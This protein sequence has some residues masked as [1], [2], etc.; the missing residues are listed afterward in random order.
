MKLSELIKELIVINSA[1][2]DIEVTIS[3]MNATEFSSLLYTFYDEDSEECRLYPE[4][5]E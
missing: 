3:N 1:V 5:K 2:G 4:P